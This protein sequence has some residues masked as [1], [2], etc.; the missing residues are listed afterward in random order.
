MVFV[1][2]RIKLISFVFLSSRML[3][4][5]NAFVACPVVQWIVR[6]TTTTEVAGSNIT[7]SSCVYFCSFSDIF[8]FIFCEILTDFSCNQIQSKC[9][10]VLVFFSFCISLHY[11]FFSHFTYGGRVSVS[12]CSF[13]NRHTVFLCYHCLSW[14]SVK[15]AITSFK[16]SK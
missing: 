12:R 13:W 11:A 15:N 4:I 7:G 3:I 8:F 16:F 10:H 6:L 5:S 1:D 2:I 9:E 14:Q